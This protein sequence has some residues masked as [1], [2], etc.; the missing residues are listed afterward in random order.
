MKSLLSS[1]GQL[2]KLHQAGLCLAVG[3]V[4]N[5]I[6]YF[7]RRWGGR[8]LVDESAGVAVI[9]LFVA[10]LISTCRVRCP[11]CGLRWFLYAIRKEPVGEWYYWLKS[12][13]VCPK[14]GRAASE[15]RGH[16]HAA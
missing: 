16:V 14:C 13:S 12:F 5:S 10:A 8:A 3:M 4:V 6:H 15:E 11:Q 9:V 1:T 2:S 7:V